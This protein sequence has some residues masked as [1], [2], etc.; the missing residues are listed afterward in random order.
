MNSLHKLLNLYLPLP[1]MTSLKVYGTF[2]ETHKALQML[3]NFFPI[4]LIRCLWQISCQEGHPTVHQVLSG[5]IFLNFQHLHPEFQKFMLRRFTDHY[6]TK[7]EI[8]S[9]VTFFKVM[10]VSAN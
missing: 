10:S 2:A 3:V 8:Q 5:T 9:D 4:F 7:K 1:P 6:T